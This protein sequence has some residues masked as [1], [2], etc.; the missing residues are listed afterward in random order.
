MGVQAIRAARIAGSSE[1][2]WVAIDDTKISEIGVDG[3]PRDAIDFGD[4]ILAPSFVDIQVNGIADADFNEPDDDAWSRGARMLLAHGV[5]SFCP[6]VI[7]QP[8]EAYEALLDVAEDARVGNPSDPPG[9]EIV[10]VHLEGPFLGGAPGAHDPDVLRSADPGWMTKAMARHPGLVRM[11]TLAP[12]ADAD[13]EL[14][15]LLADAGVLVSLGHS[16][17]TYEEAIGATDAGARAV[18][19]LFNGMSSFHH[20][21]PGLVGA[22][23]DDERLTPSLIADLVHVNPVALRLACSRKAN[24]ALVSDAI[25]TQGSWAS[26]RG[27]R[28]ID[29]APRLP[30]GTLAGSLLT[31]DQAVH[32]MTRVGISLE[33]SI[34]MASKVPAELLGLDDRGAITPGARADL[35][36]LDPDEVKVLCVWKAGE[37]VYEIA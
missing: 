5:T 29:G 2:R 26:A 31:M 32:N 15:R 24:V 11:V 19:H 7:S 18:T 21:E 37:L 20:R 16:T 34:E 13:L 23:L 4:A 36:A 12:E 6:T 22:A 17:A 10:G 3:A 8:L 33:R 30:N 1:A 25:A 9:A 28:I 27:I 14:T 35:V